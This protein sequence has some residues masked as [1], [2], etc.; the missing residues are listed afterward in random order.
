MALSSRSDL[1]NYCLHAL[2]APVLQINVAPE[3]LEERIDEA[4]E[5]FWSFHGDGSVREYLSYTLEDIDIARQY[6]VLPDHILSVIRLLPIGL[7]I[8]DFNLQ[9]AEF[10]TTLVNSQ[11][12]L[13]SSNS[14]VAGYVVAEEYVSLF[15]QFFN[16]EKTV[17]FNQYFNRVYIEA[18][19]NSYNIN[20]ILVLEC[21]RLSDPEE[22]RA[23]YNDYW[24]RSYATALVKKQWGANLMKFNNF[25]LPGGITVD[26]RSIYDQAMVEIQALEE[27]LFSTYSLP[28]DFMVG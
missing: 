8:S 19:W 20:D 1:R 2:G 28:V 15:N 5:Q 4:I 12:I 22:C 9:Y 23:V 26:G 18:D 25:Q 21:Y 7:G 6:L 13:V 3:Q 17:R 16:R 14:P 27:K 24:L 10:I 11:K